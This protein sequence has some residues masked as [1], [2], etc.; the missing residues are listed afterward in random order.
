MRDNLKRRET[1]RGR[2]IASKLSC[3]ITMMKRKPTMAATIFMIHPLSDTF[4]YQQ[5]AHSLLLMMSYHLMIVPL[6]PAGFTK[7]S[8]GPMR[9]LTS[10]HHATR[11]T[12][13]RHVTNVSE[14]AQ[15][16]GSSWL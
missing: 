11:C 4:T 12:S 2:T 1:L 6:I 3:K 10:N 7:A 5:E 14:P 16:S 15:D 13:P 9:L 8:P